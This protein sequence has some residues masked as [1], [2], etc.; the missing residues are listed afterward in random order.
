MQTRITKA[1]K[2]GKWQLVKRLQYLL[3]HSFYAKLLA[4]RT[5]CQN[6]GKRTAGIDGEKWLTPKAK[7]NAALNLSDE[8]YNPCSSV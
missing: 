4:V 1:V 7:M 5:I 8:S 2:E 3:T 6:K